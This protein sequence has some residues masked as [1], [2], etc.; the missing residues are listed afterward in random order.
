VKHPTAE[1]KIAFAGTGDESIEDEISECSTAT[2]I[3]EN[4]GYML[5]LLDEADTADDFDDYASTAETNVN[6]KFF[7]Y[8]E[9]WLGEGL[10]WHFCLIWCFR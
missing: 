3:H 5:A 9:S 4:D 1:A 10:F 6:E 8:A 7:V 2:L